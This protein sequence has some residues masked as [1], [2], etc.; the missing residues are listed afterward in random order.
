MKI[1]HINCNFEGTKLHKNLVVKLNSLGVENHIFCPVSDKTYYNDDI[2]LNVTKTFNKID[3]ILFKYKNMKITNKI[4]ELYNISDFNII[5]AHTLFTD[6]YNAYK[7]NKKYNIP[8]VVTIRNTDINTFFKY[9]IHLRSLG[10]K[11]L[12]NASKVIFLSNSYKNILL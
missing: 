9:M 11:I 5:H 6:G 10:N 2:K 12:L 1:L 7:L 3:R 4:L 8:Y